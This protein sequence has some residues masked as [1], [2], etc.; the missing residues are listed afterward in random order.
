MDVMAEPDQGMAPAQ[1]ERNGPLCIGLVV[2]PARDISEPMRELREW[3]QAYDSQ[4]VQVPA[5][6]QQQRVAEQGEA[7]ACDLLLSIGGDGTALAA[8]RAGALADRPVL[9]VACGS[10]GILTSFPASGLG[11]ALDRF[12]RGDWAPRL[13][14]G[15]EVARDDGRSLFALND[16]VVVRA[17]AGQIR[18]KLEVDG[19]LFAR[20]AGDGCIISTAIGSSAYTLA[21][22][23]PLLAPELQALAITPLSTHG[24]TCPP[25]VIGAGSTVRL[26]PLPEHGA[27]RLELD[28]QVADSVVWPLT[29]SLRPDVATVVRFPDQAAFLAVL[30]ERQILTDSP[31]ILAEDARH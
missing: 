19:E 7:E 9:S 11:D 29:I 31:R 28:G 30:R 15:L 4:L 25:F 12:R 17:S 22:R 20:L 13:L 8:I 10:L 27:P 26:E 14:P 16:L 5:S 2:H 6:C 24:G 21:A 23:G 3:A 18:L 1:A